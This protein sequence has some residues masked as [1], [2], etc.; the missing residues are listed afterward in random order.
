[1][2]FSLVVDY[3]VYYLNLVLS[4]LLFLKC[5]HAVW[6]IALKNHVPLPRFS[7]TFS[8]W[9]RGIFGTKWHRFHYCCNLWWVQPLYGI[10]TLD[11]YDKGSYNTI[12]PTT[13]QMYLKKLYHTFS[14]QSML[15]PCSYL[16]AFCYMYRTVHLERRQFS[17]KFSQKTSHSSLI[18]AR[19][20]VSFCEYKFYKSM[21][22]LSY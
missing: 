11:Y 18:G 15:K 22:H 13:R 20:G 5:F 2:I 6:Y 8:M 19:H 7:E 16:D 14:T 4:L 10:H 21:Q 12:L 3:F 1:M 17:R 9:C